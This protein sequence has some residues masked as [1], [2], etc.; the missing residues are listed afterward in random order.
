MAR[1]KQPELGVKSPYDARYGVTIGPCIGL[2]D[3]HDPS[4]IPDEAL[5][6]GTNVRVHDG[7]PISRGGQSSPTNSE[8]QAGGCIQGLIDI[9]GGGPRIV[10][11]EVRATTPTGLSD[12]DMFDQSSSPNYVR[13]TAPTTN[14]LSA[15]PLEGIGQG[16]TVVDTDRPRYA[17]LWWNGEIVF[18]GSDLALDD[19]Y[20]YRFVFP[21][22]S[23]DP[24]DVQ[25]E[26]VLH[27]CVSGESDNFQISSM[28]Q[29]PETNSNKTESAD[30]RLGPPLYFGTVGG[31]VVAYVNGELVRLLDEAT[32][33]GRTMVFEY[34]NRLY[35]AG[36]QKVMVQDAG[37]T[38]GGSPVSSS[39]TDLTM[40]V[41][42]VEFVPYCTQQIEAVCLIGGAD[43]DGGTRGSI[44]EIDDST[45]PPTVTEAHDGTGGFVCFDDFAQALGTYWVSYR[46]IPTPSVTE[47]AE[48]ATIDADATIGTAVANWVE[49]GQIPRLLGVRNALYLSAWASGQDPNEETGAKIWRYDENGLSE[50]ATVPGGG[51]SSPFDMVVF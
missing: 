49:D 36:T 50:V 1:A 47:Q 24:D 15:Q 13:V 41:S 37:W 2:D 42:P 44:L 17:F 40:P 48:F 11:A 43:V 4:M 30:P 26:P 27:L 16:S 18:G 25:V 20:L 34:N 46:I 45:A 32:F 5:V 14:R 6:D 12:I 19:D 9:N 22:E 29:L 7:I 23:F 31:G 8:N 39:F 35:A 51:E 28:C 21:D 10:L 33:T 3:S 38:D